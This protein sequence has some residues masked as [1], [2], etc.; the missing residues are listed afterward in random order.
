M[1]H[2]IMIYGI[3]CQHISENFFICLVVAIISKF[4]LEIVDFTGKEIYR[5]SDLITCFC[6]VTDFKRSYLTL[7]FQQ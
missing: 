3:S 2:S 7:L 4:L 5:N 1:L 6:G